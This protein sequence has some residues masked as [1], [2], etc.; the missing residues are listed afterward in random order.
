[1]HKGKVHM[2]GQVMKILKESV[3]FLAM[4]TGHFKIGCLLYCELTPHG[5]FSL[6][7]A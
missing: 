4:I 5:G 7:I 3:V 6:Y 2:I 1:M